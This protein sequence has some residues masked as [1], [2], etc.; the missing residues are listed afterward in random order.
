MFGTFTLQGVL[1]YI[2]STERNAG[3]AVLE[4]SIC[5]FQMALEKNGAHSIYF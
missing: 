3:N 4:L 1:W 2:E 5:G